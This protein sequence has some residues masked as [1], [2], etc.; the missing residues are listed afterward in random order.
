MKNGVVRTYVTPTNPQ[1]AAQTEIRAA[2]NFLNI[3][4]SQTL[5]PAERLAW[6]VALTV[7]YWDK[8]DPFTGT[9]RPFNS[10]KSLFI[11]MN[12]NFM[13]GDGTMSLPAVQYASPGSSTGIDAVG[14]TSITAT[15][16]AG[17]VSFA[18]T[19]TNTLEYFI[20]KMSPPVSAGNQRITSVKSSMRIV[21]VGTLAASPTA[22]GAAY[23]A[24]FGAITG[25]A[26]K[27]IFYIW[28]QVDIDTGKSRV[29]STGSTIIV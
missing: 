26:G 1:S 12:M 17:T 11:G 24:Q 6:E 7:D 8:T 16:A 29:I 22:L 15:A 23:V 5:T 4:W 25:K 27:K 2:F 18:Y 19:G 13:F 3:E 28:E 14:F 9:S 10:A 20:M 21:Q